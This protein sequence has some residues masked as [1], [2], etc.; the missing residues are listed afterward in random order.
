MGLRQVSIL[1]DG[2][3]V[4][5]N[6]IKKFGIFKIDNMNIHTAINIIKREIS[7]CEQTGETFDLPEIEN[8]NVKMNELPNEGADLLHREYSID[9]LDG[10]S[11]HIDYHSKDKS[12]VFQMNPDRSVISIKCSR[13][14]YDFRTAWDE[15]Y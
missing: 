3:K 9:F 13:P 6:G 12:R 15:K 7:Q 1:V 10:D 11:I 8:A 5:N 14:E 2:A 4:R